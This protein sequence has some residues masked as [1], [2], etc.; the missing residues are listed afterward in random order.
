MSKRNRR[1]NIGHGGA[2]PMA[3]GAARGVRAP[4]RVSMSAVFGPHPAPKAQAPA[5]FA[6]RMSPSPGALGEGERIWVMAKI[7]EPCFSTRPGRGP[8]WNLLGGRGHQQLDSMVGGADPDLRVSLIRT[9]P[10]P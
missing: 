7:P 5:D 6:I 1:G 2:S 3:G 9:V 4:A 10:G 8:R